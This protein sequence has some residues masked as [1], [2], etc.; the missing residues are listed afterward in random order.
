MDAACGE[1]TII[2][3]PASKR[4]EVLT[5]AREGIHRVQQLLR[6]F[7]RELADVQTEMESELA[8]GGLAIFANYFFDG[9]IVDWVVQSKILLDTVRRQ[10]AEVQELVLMLRQKLQETWCRR[11]EVREQRRRVVESAS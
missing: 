2:C 1:R 5:E 6:L 10:S 8:I 4:L 3:D 9:L 11:E 7:Q